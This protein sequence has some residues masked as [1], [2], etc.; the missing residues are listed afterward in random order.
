LCEASGVGAEIDLRA[1][2]LSKPLRAYAAA[3][4]R[5]PV[6][7]ALGG[8]EDFEL[9]FTVPPTGLDRALR[10]ATG[11]IP[12]TAIGRVLP[13]RAGLRMI[14]ASGA[15]RPLPAVGYEHFKGST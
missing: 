2:P 8:G 4:R 6:D 5:D 3:V 13:R 11:E 10:L 12:I 15:R 1:L 7:Y 9:L 14:D